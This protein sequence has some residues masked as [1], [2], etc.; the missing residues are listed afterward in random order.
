MSGPLREPTY[1]GFVVEYST[2]DGRVLIEH[3]GGV[4]WWKAPLPRRLHRCRA[5]TSGLVM[6]PWWGSLRR[7]ALGFGFCGSGN[8]AR[9][10]ANLLSYS[11]PISG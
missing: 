2:L 8:E 6:N 10:L 9:L 1:P 5:Q 3:R 7:E 11:L 4:P